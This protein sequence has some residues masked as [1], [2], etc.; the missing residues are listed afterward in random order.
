MQIQVNT[1][2]NVQGGEDLAIRVQQIVSDS[3]DHLSDRI[4]RIEA[5]LSD[6]NSDKGGAQDKRCLLEARLAGLPPIAVK[7][8]AGSMA[9][10]VEGAAE[11]LR[12]ALGRT[13]G[14]LADSPRA[15]RGSHELE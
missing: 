2:R 5:H 13:L 1:D 10:A 9:Q 15:T 7:H 14:K 12:T 8:S 4:T 3:V 6:E 11:K